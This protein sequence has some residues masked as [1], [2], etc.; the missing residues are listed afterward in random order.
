MAR[1]VAQLKRPNFVGSTQNGQ[2]RELIGGNG[3]T[4]W[5]LVSTTESKQM[6]MMMM[7]ST[8][9]FRR[10]SAFF[11]TFLRASLAAWLFL[12]KAA[13]D[14]LFL[15]VADFFDSVNAEELQHFVS[16]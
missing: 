13:L 16:S 3:S 11:L 2:G 8:L 9:S 1:A 7:M 4:C 10:R 14:P 12:G 6:M 5:L 15:A